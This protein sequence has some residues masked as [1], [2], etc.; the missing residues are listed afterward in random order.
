MFANSLHPNRVC[1]PA[2]LSGD[3]DR[4]FGDLLA[5]PGARLSTHHSGDWQARLAVWEK[6]DTLHLELELPGV[7]R[8]D[9]ELTVED[10]ALKIAG[11]RKAAEDEER[12]EHY[13]ERRFGRFERVVRLPKQFD[14]ESVAAELSDGV[15]HV[16]IDK[17]PE[18]QPKRIDV[19]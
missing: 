11:E 6:E 5:V 13:S 17:T 19:K 16:T 9:V 12:H 8:D 3:I 10:G 2:A 7:V 4:L 15:L 1:G 18:S 14:L